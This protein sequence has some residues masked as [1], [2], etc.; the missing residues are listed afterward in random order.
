MS[1]NRRSGL[2]AV[3]TAVTV[4]V[5]AFGAPVAASAAL[6][7]SAGSN[8]LPGSVADLP[9]S[10]SELPGS[11]VD[12]GGRAI[13]LGS[14]ILGNGS[15]LP[16]TQQCNQSRQSGGEGVTSTYHELGRS[17]PTSFLLDWETFDVPDRIQVFYG[18]SQIHDTGRIGDSIN[19][20]T[21]SAVV[22][23][24]AGSASSVLVR[25]TG[26]PGTAWEYTVNCPIL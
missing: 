7:G 11:V 3:L 15:S 2:R 21:G 17:G 22:N 12:L 20:G 19:E 14:A 6:T 24:P 26:E 18:G 5:V 25:V 8:D 9:G 4:A 23:V 16:S 1:R 13:D 10:V